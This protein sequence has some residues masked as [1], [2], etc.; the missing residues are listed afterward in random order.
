MYFHDFYF[1]WPHIIDQCTPLFSL[2]HPITGLTKYTAHTAIKPH[3]VQITC[4]KHARSVKGNVEWAGKQP[5]TC[6]VLFCSRGSLCT[7]TS[8]VHLMSCWR[9][10]CDFEKY[11]VSTSTQITSIE[12]KKVPYLPLCICTTR[13]FKVELPFIM[14]IVDQTKYIWFTNFHAYML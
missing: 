10:T 7:T 12:E 3:Q 6:R 8:I 2:Q 11:H 13:S 9:M 1:I 4:H 5:R 14:Q